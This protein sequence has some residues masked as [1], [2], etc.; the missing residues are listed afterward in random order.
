MFAQYPSAVKHCKNKVKTVV[1]PKCK[2]EKGK[3]NLK[4]HIESCGKVVEKTKVCKKCTVCST[5]FSTKQRL[6]Y[7]L[8]HVHKIE[9]PGIEIPAELHKCP[10]CEFAHRL[11]SV[12]K[13]HQTKLHKINPK[14][15]CKE[16]GCEYFCF[17]SSGMSKH[18]KRVHS[19]VM[20]LEPVVPTESE[21]N[22]ISSPVKSLSLN[23]PEN[24][25][26]TSSL[27]SCQST[28]AC[29]S[30]GD[31]NS[32]ED[33]PCT[34]S[35]INRHSLVQADM[36]EFFPS[37]NIADKYVLASNYSIENEI[38]SNSSSHYVQQGDSV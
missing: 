29:I 25:Q 2:K 20:R 34:S 10:H 32:H 12:V 22:Q 11:L 16:I 31:L 28:E 13:V 21:I 17:S 5:T 19:H 24:V 18:I 35:S 6:N 33:T 38:S 7:Y 4:R 36:S 27:S 14:L 26:L 23:T 8:E 9:L 37:Y 1:C 3:R 30:A 15:Y